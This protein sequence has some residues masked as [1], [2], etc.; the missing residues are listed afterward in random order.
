MLTFTFTHDF[1]VGMIAFINEPIP[2]PRQRVIR[3]SDPEKS[4]IDGL[5][6]GQGIQ[7]PDRKTAMCAVSRLR[8]SGKS[9]TMQANA[10][11][12]VNVWRA[13]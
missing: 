9:A 13:A 8:R 2:K 12:T 1:L 7:F 3:L 5:A 4:A 11:G 10:D 6:V